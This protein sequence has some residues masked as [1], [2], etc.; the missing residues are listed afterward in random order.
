MKEN[1]CN[2]IARQKTKLDDACKHYQNMLKD[3][4]IKLQ[5]MADAVEVARSDVSRLKSENM[6]NEKAREDLKALVQELENN[7]STLLKD[8]ADA[9]A[10]KQSSAKSHVEA[11]QNISTAQ[12]STINT[13]IKRGHDAANQPQPLNRTHDFANQPQHSA[14]AFKVRA[15]SEAC[16]SDKMPTQTN[17]KVA[18]YSSSLNPSASPPSA[19]KH[20]ESPKTKKRDRSKVIS[21]VCPQPLRLNI[22]SM[23]KNFR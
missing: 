6:Q 21:L 5:L 10:E 20:R 23:T 1:L 14:S 18:Q 15:S 7:I 9:E 2:E 16:H 13:K 19:K 11:P 4:Q 22:F 12:G 3:E 17:S 8:Q